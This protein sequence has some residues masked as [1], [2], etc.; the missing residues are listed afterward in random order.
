MLASSGVD[1]RNP[2]I[3]PIGYC[4]TSR[5]EREADFDALRRSIERTQIGA[6][7]VGIDIVEQTFDRRVLA[8]PHRHGSD[9]QGSS[10]RVKVKRRLR[11]SA[12]S[13][14]IW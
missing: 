10:G 5:R 8:L 11:L 4:D 6:Q 13:T 3:Y 1:R 2:S 12:S 9:E 14:D 7:A